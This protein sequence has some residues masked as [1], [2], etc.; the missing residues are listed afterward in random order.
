MRKSQKGWGT[1][2]SAKTRKI[3]HHLD[4]VCDDMRKQK[5]KIGKKSKEKV[6]HK[7]VP[8]PVYSLGKRRPQNWG[9]EKP[10]SKCAPRWKEGTRGGETCRGGDR[11]EK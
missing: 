10:R 8:S 2:P 9:C 5:G 3:T 6:D 1:T 4:A 7:G 11:E